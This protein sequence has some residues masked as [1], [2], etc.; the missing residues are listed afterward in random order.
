MT[1]ARRLCVRARLFTL[2]IL[3]RRA[4]I[5]FLRPPFG[6]ALTLVFCGEHTFSWYSLLGNAKIFNSNFEFL[7]TT[8][9]LELSQWKWWPDFD[10]NDNKNNEYVFT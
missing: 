7:A 1:F 8:I 2:I 3:R 4:A 5:L 10:D 6:H 9:I